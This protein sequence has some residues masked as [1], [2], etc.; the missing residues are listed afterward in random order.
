MFTLV[1]ALKNPQVSNYFPVVGGYF[2]PEEA[3][4]EPAVFKN[5]T[6]FKNRHMGVW[7]EFL[8]DVHL[9]GPKL[10]DHQKAGIEFKYMNGEPIGRDFESRNALSSIHAF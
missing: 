6:S 3:V 5:F 2:C 4:S 10:A 8:V 9:E 1:A 7:G